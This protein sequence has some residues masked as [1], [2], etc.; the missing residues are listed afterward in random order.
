MKMHVHLFLISLTPIL[1][2][3]P[4]QHDGHSPQVMKP[5][6]GD[7]IWTSLKS[8]EHRSSGGKLRI[9]VESK[10]HP[11]ASA[12]FAKFT[13]GESG[14]LPVHR[15]EKTEEF[16]YSLSGEGNAGF[17]D[18]HGN[19]SEIPE[20]GD[21][22]WHNPAGQ[23]H[24]ARNTGNT[25]L[26]LVF[27]TVPSK[28]MGLLSF[29]RKIGSTSRKLGTQITVDQRMRIGADH[30]MTLRY[31]PEEAHESRRSCKNPR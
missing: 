19:E 8:H 20:S 23:W 18:D 30:V 14:A 17:V 24:S 2:C 31:D 26:S 1:G 7:R 15:H 5:D 6:K 27:A 28:E 3:Q 4:T 9:Y 10:P 12:S 22:V 25:P 16:A 29:F 11:H 13:L 21:F